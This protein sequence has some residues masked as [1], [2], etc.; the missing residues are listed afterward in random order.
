MTYAALC[1]LLI[2][3]DDLSRVDRAAC[4]QGIAALQEEDGGFLSSAV[5]GEKDVR[6]V[7]SAAVSA[8]ILGDISAINIDKA[9]E[10]VQRCQVSAY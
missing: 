2:L 5:G 6:F 7:Y 1:S 3:G 10:Y 8:Y 9:M 4:L